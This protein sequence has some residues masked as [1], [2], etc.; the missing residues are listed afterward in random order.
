ME[1]K[2]YDVRIT[3]F[4]G[5]NA[6][7][8]D[9]LVPPSKSI[10]HRAV[11]C[12]SLSPGESMVENLV[13]SEDIKTTI[14]A[15][16]QF[17]ASVRLEINEETKRYNAFISNVHIEQLLD[18]NA[19]KSSEPLEIYCHESGSTARFLIPFFHLI[20]GA[21]TFKG[22]DRLS[23]R[24]YTPYLEIFDLQKI[25]YQSENGG[26]PLTVK[27]KFKAGTYTMVGNVSSQFI[28]GLMFILP[29]LEEKSQIVI[30]PPLESK[31]YI[32]LTVDCLEAFG[33]KIE[34]KD[35]LNYVVQ[36]GQ[37]YR[38]TDFIVEGDYSQAAFWLVANALGADIR[39]KGINAQSKQADRAIINII[40][41]IDQRD[42]SNETCIIDVAQCP[43][44]VPIVA[45][46]CA[47]KKGKYQIVNAERL[48]IK[49]SDRLK[50]IATELSKMGADIL[51]TPD[52]LIINGVETLVG[53]EVD[54]WN[55]HRIA[56]AL[57]IAATRATGQTIIREAQC[58]N[59]SYPNFWDE[60][61]ILGGQAS[62][63]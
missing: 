39:L 33:I 5:S 37:A 38:G 25:K 36:G 23:E 46:Y 40:K 62:V 56:M 49:E 20:N 3:Q 12:A 11:I 29:L 53:A 59:K 61:K 52:G 50:A 10:S 32:A 26:L 22:T 18:G 27:G 45:V 7:K 41:R 17:G 13:L 2:S 19:N 54:A 35:S 51:E 16:R 47:L 34:E 8:G 43:D 31:D 30:T 24:P 55:D 60:Y 1:Q 28:S 4:N 58:V 63:E 44:I 21:V 42:W 14:E 9:L 57:A 15:M 48:R 6:L